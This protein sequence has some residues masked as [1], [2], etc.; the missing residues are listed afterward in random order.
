M[1]FEQIG[2]FLALAEEGSFVAAA[3]R[4]GIS[5]P[6]LS[7]AIK[8]LEAS[9]G[10]PLFKRTATGAEL[11]AFGTAMRP[12]LSGLH[13]DRRRALE[14]ADAFNRPANGKSIAGTE[15]LRARSRRGRAPGNGK[16]IR[17]IG[18]LALAALLVC[19]TIAT[20][21]SAWA[22][23]SDVEVAIR[24]VLP[25]PFRC[26]GTIEPALYCRHDDADQAMV[27]E[28]TSG[29][30]GP[31][32]SLTYDYDDKRRHELLAIMRE[33]FTRLGVDGDAFDDCISQAQ[34]QPGRQLAN[35]RHI[36]CYHIEFGDR[37]TR[38]VFAKAAGET[39]MLAHAAEVAR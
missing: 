31:S 15:L 33:F 20:A 29:P 18:V 24:E 21:S 32:A 2:Y 37:V 22:G 4:F 3:R 10:M 30:E 17:G 16:S 38:E 34:W 14:F 39:P 28:L 35:G 12:L 5:Q 8:S 26:T 13:A 23:E 1:T 36:L 25:T 11:T 27:L 7:N 9:L 19:A 6:S